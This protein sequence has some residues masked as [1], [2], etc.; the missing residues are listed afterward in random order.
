MNTKKLSQSRPAR[1]RRAGDA[2]TEAVSALQDAIDEHASKI[3]DALSELTDL[4]GEYE[5]WYNNLPEGLQQSATGSLLEEIQNLDI[6]E[7]C[8]VDTLQE[9]IEFSEQADQVVL[10]QGFGRD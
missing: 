9:V 7:E 8:T 1:W 5:E 3:N 10:P 4:Q 2:L 6:P